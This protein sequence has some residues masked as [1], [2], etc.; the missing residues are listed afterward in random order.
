[1]ADPSIGGAILGEAVHFVDLMYWLLESEPITV[2][3]YCLPT[4]KDDP[5]GENN[6]VATF[7]FVDGSIGSLNYSTLGSGRAA[8][9]RVEV[10]AKGM[11]GVVENFKKLRIVSNLTQT[12][13]SLWAQKGY[14][15]QLESFFASIVRSESPRVTVR[16][17]A[18]ATTVCVQMLQAALTRTPREIDL[19]KVLTG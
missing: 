9:E 7:G 19:D 17:G 18:R 6:M 1:M 16:D 2:S 14:K 15:T 13:S 4:D 10:F 5:V 11:T 12:R 8:G 3:A